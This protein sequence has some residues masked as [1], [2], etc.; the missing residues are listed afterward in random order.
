MITFY[1][2]SINYRE[3]VHI[4]IEN[5]ITKSK[6]KVHFVYSLRLPPQRFR[7][8]EMQWK[9]NLPVQGERHRG[10]MRPMHWQAFW[11]DHW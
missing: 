5:V 10:E 8:V 1:L 11:T 3:H 7:D 6:L 9:W 2:Q 4:S